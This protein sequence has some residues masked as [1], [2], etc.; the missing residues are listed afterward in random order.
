MGINI[1]KMQGYGNDFMMD[2]PLTLT[3]SRR[4]R[5]CLYSYC[6]ISDL[7]CIISYNIGKFFD[8]GMTMGIN[9]TKMQGCGNDFVIIDYAEYQKGCE[10]KRWENMSEASKILCDRHLV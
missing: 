4:A 1:T 2:C 9:I 7:Y 6:D 3:L 10:A 8:K 5:V